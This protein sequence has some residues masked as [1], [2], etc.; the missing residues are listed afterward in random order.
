MLE[1]GVRCA[2][3][4]NGAGRVRAESVICNLKIE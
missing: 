4:R 2:S 1:C 3:C